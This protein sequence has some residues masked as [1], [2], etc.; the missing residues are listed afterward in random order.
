MIIKKNDFYLRNI[1]EGGETDETPDY[2]QEPID[3]AGRDDNN[4]GNNPPTND[5][6]NDAPPQEGENEEGDEKNEHTF[7]RLIHKDEYAASL[8]PDSEQAG[9]GQGTFGDE[10]GHLCR[11]RYEN[12]LLSGG[13]A[14]RHGS[15]ADCFRR[16]GL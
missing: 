16:A 13:Y 11:N 15:A 8:E 4:Q 3:P 7:Q 12:L 10:Y 6:N 5:Q 9:Q 1:L 2:T 14:R